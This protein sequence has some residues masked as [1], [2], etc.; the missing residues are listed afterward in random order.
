MPPSL[1]TW[2]KWLAACLVCL[3]SLTAP[4][5]TAA[6][7]V[8]SE[9]L[10]SNSGGLADED[11]DHPDWI[12]L[13]NG[14]TTTA[15][16][17]GWF[18][19]DSAADPTRWRLPATNMPP[20]GFLVVF[21][22]GKNRA[23]AGAPLHANFSL[24]AAGEYLALVLPDGVT[25]S[26]E[27]A[28]AF[29]EQLAGVSYGIAQNILTTLLV[30]NSSP[31]RV[32]VPSNDVGRAWV[33]NS[34]DDATWLA[35]TN[36]VGY[37]AFVSG[38]A[39]RNVRANVGVCDLGT[40]ESVLATPSLQAASFTAAP[41][42]INYVNTGSGANF[43]GDVTFPGLTI[44]VDAENFV[45]E[46]TGII[47]I[48]TAGLWTFG[49][50]SDDGFSCTIG[51][52][53][54]SYASPRGP[55]D[56]FATFNLVAGDYPVRLVFY[57]CGGGSELEF[58]AA[59]G[60]RSSFSAAFRLVGNT[61]GGG[62]A[63]KSLPG[64]GG[65]ANFR[66]LIARDLQPQMY[67]RQ[68]TAYLRL[69]FVVGDVADFSSLKLRMKYD[70]GF[71][72]YLNGVEVARDNAPAAPLWSSIAV[73]N[74]SNTLAV[75]FKDFDLTTSLGLLVNGTN[76]LAIHGL[77]DAIGSSEFLQFAELGEYKV[78]GTADH[79]FATP[80]PGFANG[81]D[82][83]AFVENLKFTPGRGWYSNAV[84][85]TITSATP[86][87]SIRYTLDGSAPSAMAGTLYTGAA[88]TVTNTAALRAVGYR[89]GFEST[90]PETH[91]YI[92]LDRVIRQ[93][94]AGFPTD[95]AG[96]VPEYAMSPSI[97]NDP[98]WAP[99]MRSD[100]LAVPTLS[101]AMNVDELFGRNGIYVNTGAEG[102]A[103]ERA[104]SME[105]IRPDGQKGFHI[106]CGIRIQ[107]GV[108]RS[109]MRKH[110]LRVLFKSLYGA[111]KLDYDLY[112]NSPVKEF[113]TL[114]LHGAF[115]DHWGWVG[116][117]A[118]LQRD[119]WCRDAQNDLGGYGPHGTYV[120]L[121]LNG[122]YWGLYNIGEKG[123]GSFASQ[124]R[125]GSRSGGR[126]GRC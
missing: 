92:F 26:S 53:A 77:N 72:A 67:N 62:L 9:F 5:G 39:V 6:T 125:D 71:I 104:C 12:E 101:I 108:S 93:T 49:V 7:V 89:A 36:G 124:P 64:A 114:T 55:G 102:A 69:P 13:F 75:A 126:G 65:G 61:A 107:G 99:T 10:A 80:T 18:L 4:A 95:W 109:A 87:L 86:G 31:V 60:S 73:A 50:N 28:P 122:L 106:N 21:A 83:F 47:T 115:N 97:V 30:S 15:N 48:P 118:Q 40:A 110:G 59:A 112:P 29:P 94:G 52:S 119:Q 25:V 24:S 63:V 57:E 43:G 22:S 78:V 33:A 14:G 11:L 76:L 96:V 74:R 82:T 84:S 103:W 19:T 113:D 35:G 81:S 54:F 121:Y 56:T 51:S 2:P 3:A 70:D 37:Q 120:H 98:R 45:I 85:V 44:N 41:P 17:D 20:G 91:S 90:A 16:L 42:T 116:A 66:P 34:F 8:I 32:F 27:F 58:F 38:F 105:Y 111:G 117:A 68:P 123:D 88:I 23:V 1:L 46:A 79:Y 100:L